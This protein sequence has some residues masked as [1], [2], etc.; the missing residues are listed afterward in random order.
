MNKLLSVFKSEWFVAL[1][2]LAGYA[3]IS[4]YR[5]GMPGVFYDELLY[6]NAALGMIDSNFVN[7]HIGSFPILLMDYIGA[8]KAWIYYPI[9]RIF[10]VSVFS[11]RFPNIAFSSMTLVFL[12]MF[13]RKQMG[14]ST[15]L[16]TLIIT[17]FDPSFIV[18]ERMDFGPTVI[19]LF[20]RV[21]SLIVIFKFIEK[22]HLKYGFLLLV[23]LLAGTFNKIDF[24][25]FASSVILSMVL[26]YRST[27]LSFIRSIDLFQRRMIFI[28]FFTGSI[29]AIVFLWQTKYYQSIDLFYYSHLVRVVKMGLELIGGTGFYNSYLGTTNPIFS[30]VLAG[31]CII[32]CLFRFIYIIRSRIKNNYSLRY[33]FMVSILVM[34]GFQIVITN[35]SGASWHL[36]SLYPIPQ[37]L[38]A[39]ALVWL[40]Q[41]K[42]ITA[43]ALVLVFSLYMGLYFSYVNYIQIRDYGNPK[44]IY[45]SPAI[46]ELIRYAKTQ[47]ARFVS[48]DWG[49]H[50]QL[51]TF[52]HKKG[53]YY[54]MWTKLVASPL[55]SPFIKRFTK[56]FVTTKKPVIFILYANRY[57]SFPLARQNFFMIVKQS[58][59]TMRKVKEISNNDDVVYELY[60]VSH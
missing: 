59:A 33:Y 18:H 23:C 60:T 7:L 13:V 43:N 20:F 8:L 54:D 25:W 24:V 53:K 46:Y 41:R 56:D 44:N 4:V 42:N 30:Y 21:V 10:G 17:S 50:T 55:H 57:E 5:I 39:D 58:N 14:K 36:F 34:I 32:L 45:W 22:K 51:Q 11:I 49:T 3:S 31:L 48:V 29:L 26:I 9:F 16:L 1:V 52:D 28:T 12:Y 35:K 37:I 2:L 27:L 40:I 47:D 19:A 15:A 38:V 6:T